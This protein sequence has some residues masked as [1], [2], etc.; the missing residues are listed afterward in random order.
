MKKLLVVGAI[1]ALTLSGC[2][3]QQ[4]AEDQDLQQQ[5][6]ALQEQLDK[7]REKDLQA[8]NEELQEQIDDLKEEEQEEEQEENQEE[9]QEDSPQVVI[10]NSELSPEEAEEGVV[11][12]SPD[13][14]PPSQNSEEVNVINAAIDY[15]EHAELGDYEATYSRLNSQDQA[16]F[17][18][19]EWVLS[20]TNLGSSAAEFVVYDVYPEGSG[21][22]YVDLTIYLPDGSTQPR[23]T[24]FVYE[25]GSWKK[26]LTSEEYD[27][28][29]SAL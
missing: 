4:Q 14:V 19:E 18:L 1:L 16:L 11:V 5:N 3:G 20:N 22:Y 24:Q 15:Y 23:T 13:L 21:R 8:Q 25:D 27:M 12:V 2:T 10:N 26:W 29:A 6:Q 28:F 9:E 7:E 17:S